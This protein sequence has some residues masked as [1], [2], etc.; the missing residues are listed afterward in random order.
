MKT[1]NTLT[2]V[3]FQPTVVYTNSGSL[4]SYMKYLIYIFFSMEISCFLKLI[5]YI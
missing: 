5:I 4:E 3:P 2:I 1:S